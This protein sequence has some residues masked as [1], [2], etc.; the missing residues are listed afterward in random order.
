[1]IILETN[2]LLPLF[3]TFQ[4]TITDNTILLESSVYAHIDMGNKVHVYKYPIREFYGMPTTKH[5]K[6]IIEDF[7]LKCLRTSKYLDTTNKK[8]KKK[9]IYLDSIDKFNPNFEEI[10]FNKYP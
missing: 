3:P 4:E 8:V 5:K 7:L 2:R 10:L 6:L 1:M 9:L